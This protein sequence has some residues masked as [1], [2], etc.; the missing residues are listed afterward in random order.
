[1]RLED[2]EILARRLMAE[3]RLTDWEFGFDHKKRRSRY[4]MPRK[5]HVAYCT[6]GG[7]GIER[8]GRD[9]YLQVSRKPTIFLYAPF[10]QAADESVLTKVILHE[11]GHALAGSGHNHDKHWKQLVASIGGCFCLTQDEWDR[12]LPVMAGKMREAERKANAML[13]LF[14]P[15]STP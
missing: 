4:L 12:I 5:L 7:E 11:V 9:R 14:S 3:H 10:A 1:M 6:Y 2:A 8:V 13:P 15:G